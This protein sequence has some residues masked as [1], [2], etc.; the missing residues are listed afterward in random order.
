MTAALA[1][2]FDE[3]RNHTVIQG[4]HRIAQREDVVLSTL[5][6]S[7]VAACLWDES[8]GVGGMNHF[9]LPHVA[10]RSDKDRNIIRGVH[11]MELLINDLLKAGASRRA[12]QAKLFGGAWLREGLTNVG[13]QN[14]TFAERFL[15]DEA[16]PLVGGSLRGCRGRRLQF[17]PMSGRARQVWL[18]SDETARAG[19]VA[20]PAESESGSAGELELF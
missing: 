15:A 17:W 12:M 2:S 9:L 3:A 18:I 14:A 1:D 8:V 4:Q 13:E 7:C 20:P 16:I 11:A 6:G 10:T 5:L 19:P